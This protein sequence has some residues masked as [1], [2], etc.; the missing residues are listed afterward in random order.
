MHE[1]APKFVA[2]SVSHIST[3]AKNGS[4]TELDYLLHVIRSDAFHK[5]NFRYCIS[6]M[7]DCDLIDSKRCEAFLKDD[8]FHRTTVR[9]EGIQG[10]KLS[11]IYWKYLV[12][13]L[14]NQVALSEPDRI[15]FKT[16]D[17]SEETRSDPT[18]TPFI[19]ERLH[20]IRLKIMSSD[21]CMHF[22]NEIDNGYMRS[23]VGLLKV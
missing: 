5:E 18:Q 19:R 6:G 2:Q 13:D 12:E 21:E 1:E 15:I 7:Q 9:I 4:R 16:S 3:C 23:L 8:R 14:R 17:I 20:H 10:T 11:I 22:W